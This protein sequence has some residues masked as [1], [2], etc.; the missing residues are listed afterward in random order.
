MEDDLK[1]V[2]TKLNKIKKGSRRSKKRERNDLSDSDSSWSAGLDSTRE[3]AHIANVAYKTNK[4]KIES[5][6]TDPIKIIPLDVNHTSFLEQTKNSP[7]HDTC[8]VT[9]VEAVLGP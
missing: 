5:Y 9:A 1:K 7:Q 2:R 8:G 3:L 6:P 4:I